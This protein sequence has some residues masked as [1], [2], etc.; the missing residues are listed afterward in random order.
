MFLLYHVSSG[1]VAQSPADRSRAHLSHLP[2]A[3]QF[4]IIF[5]TSSRLTTTEYRGLYLLHQANP[6]V[7]VYHVTPV[8]VLRSDTIRS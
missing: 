3:A 2:V 4:F 6:Q 7:L 5:W 8:F 1:L